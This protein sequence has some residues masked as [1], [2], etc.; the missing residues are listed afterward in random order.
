MP[1]VAIVNQKGGTGK[2][3]L[4]INLASVLAEKGAVLLLDA[5]PQAS[6]QNWAAG[7]WTSPEGL[8]V[9]GMGK[10]NLLEQVRSVSRDYDWII[11]DGPPGISR[12]SAD[13]VRAADLVLIPAKPSPLDVWAASDIVEAVRARQKTSNGAPKAAFVIT[14]AQP[15]TR[16]GRQIDAALSEMGIPVLQART[17]QRVSYPNAI[18]DGNSVVDGADQTARNEILAI[19][20][21]LESMT[22]DN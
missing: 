13:A 2:T 5:D 14:M 3:T 22:H 18:N 17:T 6:S 8:A 7:E 1:V 11:I 21:E 19:R 4:A 20:G 16:L 9:K 12:T 10:G 15:R